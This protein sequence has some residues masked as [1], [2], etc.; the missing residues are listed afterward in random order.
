MN[1]LTQLNSDVIR[2]FKKVYSSDGNIDLNDLITED[3]EFYAHCVIKLGL[4]MG[5]WNKIGNIGNTGSVDHIFF[6][7]TPDYGDP[8]VKVSQ[9]WW[10]WK[11]NQE[12][13]KIGKLY[14]MYENSEIGIVMNPKNI[15]HRII[16]GKYDG[17]Y[18]EYK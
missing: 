12:Q 17:F 16:T 5:F 10:V 13:K 6:R 3:V 7:D 14:G 11:I 9:N 18:P 4:K 8:Q 2:V 1:D 15:V